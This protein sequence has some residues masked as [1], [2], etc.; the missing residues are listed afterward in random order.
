MTRIDACNPM[1]Q[2]VDK[3]RLEVIVVVQFNPESDDRLDIFVANP[4]VLPGAYELNQKLPL[5]S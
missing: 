2:G 5:V 3:R 4:D 1:S